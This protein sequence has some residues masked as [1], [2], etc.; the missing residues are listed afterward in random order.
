MYYGQTG[1]S[2]GFWEC[3]I[4]VIIISIVIV[5]TMI[6]GISK[7]HQSYMNHIVIEWSLQKGYAEYHPQ[8]GELIML[9]DGVKEL[10]E[11]STGYKRIN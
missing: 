2:I 9:D 10:L 5:S 8:T 11:M 6:W 7:M 4:T 3:C 1:V